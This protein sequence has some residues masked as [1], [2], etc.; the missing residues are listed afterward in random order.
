MGE[1]DF[2]IGTVAAPAVGSISKKPS[3][4]ITLE[5]MTK[6][7]ATVRFITLDKP[8]LLV[9]FV[10]AK[11][12]FSDLDEEEILSDFSTVLAGTPKEN[13]LDMMFP[14]HKIVHIRSL[15]FNAHKPSTLTK[16]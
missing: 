7:K 10:Q 1:K 2:A 16:Q 3:Y 9:G 15:V 8:D 11:G 13:F 4:L 12:V 6:A 5:N 14:V